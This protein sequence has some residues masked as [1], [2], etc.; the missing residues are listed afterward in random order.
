MGR[1]S[2]EH[3]VV[4]AADASSAIMMA[5]KRPLGSALTGSKVIEATA[6]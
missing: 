6:A 3:A 1:S 5:A 4:R 2:A